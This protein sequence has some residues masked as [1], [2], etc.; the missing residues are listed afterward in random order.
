M[1]GTVYDA[2]SPSLFVTGMLRPK[3]LQYGAGAMTL[4]SCN[5]G[6]VDPQR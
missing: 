3:V 2:A 4:R 5:C 6:N 1:K